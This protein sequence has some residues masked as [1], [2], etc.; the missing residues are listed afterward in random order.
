MESIVIKM[1]QPL[2]IISNGHDVS[3][4]LVYATNS[5]PRADLSPGPSVLAWRADRYLQTQ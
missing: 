4:R 1:A 2:I 5:D 3:L